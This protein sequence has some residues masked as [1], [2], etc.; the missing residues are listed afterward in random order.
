MS[1]ALEGIR[2]LDLSRLLPGPACTW[3]LAGQGARIDRVEPPRGGDPTRS[4]PPLQEGIGV[5]YRALNAGDRSLALDLRSPEAPAVLARLLPHYDVLVDGFRPGVLE[6]LGLG[7]E[8]LRTDFPRLVVARLSGFGQDGPWSS[9]PGHDLNYVGLA[10]MLGFSTPTPEAPAVPPLQAADLG[11]A[12][13]AAFGVCA[14]LVARAS[15]G[16]GRVLDVSLTEAALSMMAPHIATLTADG[17]EPRPGGEML[18]GALPIY[19]TY[20]CADGR[21]LTVGAL[22]PQF[23]AALSAQVGP[24]DQASLRAAF[25]ARPRDAWVELLAGA[26]VGPVLLPSELADHPHFRARGAVR[27]L[28]RTSFVRPPLAPSDWRPGAVARLGEH[29]DAILDEAGL[30]AARR[31]D[32]RERGAIR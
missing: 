3:Y 2:I 6:K 31:A 13:V 5:F 32:L 28:G 24:V 15:T 25:A 9:R 23:Q 26:C 11:G 16:R 18:T 7:S 22:E 20:R 27:R 12:L 17:R 4:L 29:T 19:G 21:M 14:A 10:G 1:G 30:G 8:R